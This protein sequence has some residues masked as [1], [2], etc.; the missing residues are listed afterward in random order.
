MGTHT[1][2]Q[3][4]KYEIARELLN[5]KIADLSAQI[6]VEERKGAPDAALIDC[7]EA[8]MLDVAREIDQLNVTDEDA[9]DAAIDRN[10]RDPQ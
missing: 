2:E 1:Y 4:L 3:T 10:R 6:G 5:W 8:K 9:L 7:L